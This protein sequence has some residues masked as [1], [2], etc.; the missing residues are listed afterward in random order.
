M[1]DC[2]ATTGPVHQT[3]THMHVACA[4]HLKDPRLLDSPL[5]GSFLSLEADLGLWLTA[6]EDRPEAAQYKTAHRDLGL[7][8]YAACSGLYRQAFS[9]LRAFL[10]VSMAAVKFSASEI[11]R[12]QWI[13]GRR[14]V[15]WTD[16]VSDETGLYSVAYLR[17]FMPEAI[18]ERAQLLS[19]A[20]LAYRRCSEY[21]HGNV[22]TSALLPE[23]I[24][25]AGGIV[26]EWCDISIR[27]VRALHHCLFVRYFNELSAHARSRIEPA[28]EQ[29]FANLKSVRLTLGL[30][31]EEST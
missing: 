16:V 5:W 18:D 15:S 2:H 29:H 25:F 6:L 13:N 8:F 10:E 7:A 12:R 20:R 30:P 3:L 21:L 27:A 1:A 17:E 24:E 14:D 28:L 19:D 9:S 4:N 23:S 26:D 22:A 31:V 11:E